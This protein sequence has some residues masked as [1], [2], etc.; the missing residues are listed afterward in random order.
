[1]HDHAHAGILYNMERR[2][3][4]LQGTHTRTLHEERHQVGAGHSTTPLCSPRSTQF[5]HLNL[6]RHLQ[7]LAA[8]C[9]RVAA[10]AT[11]WWHS[12]AVRGRIWQF[13]QTVT[14][15]KDIAC[16]AHICSN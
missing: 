4:A 6:S 8:G 3:R 15:Q 2:F 7:L 1:M 16:A 11:L 14:R 13:V 10:S 9:Q 5:S 12:I